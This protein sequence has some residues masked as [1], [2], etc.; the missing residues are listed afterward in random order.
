MSHTFLNI[1]CM[2]KDKGMPSYP[3]KH[4]ELAIVDPP[5]GI[6][7]FVMAS[8]THKVNSRNYKKGLDWNE[9]TPDQKYFDE[10][11]RV[12]VRRIIWGANYYN[13]FNPGGALVWNKQTGH[14]NIS[15]CE[16]ASLSFQKKVDYVEIPWASGFLR[17]VLEDQTIH[18]CQK[19]KKLYKW[20]LTKYA[21]PGDKILDT[22]VGSAS[23]IIACIDLGFD[24]TGF[25]LDADY[26]RAASK[27]ISDFMAQTKL[28]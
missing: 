13:C 7:N 15:V 4:F 6:G 23:S 20:L 2:D 19:P 16:I 28:F 17:E 10:L 5:Y 18:P 9:N 3:D 1:D 25:E 22:H 26:Y 24:V 12:S 8:G 21:K 11:E 27:R 14:P